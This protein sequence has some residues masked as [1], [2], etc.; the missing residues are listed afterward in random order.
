VVT[1]NPVTL[2]AERAEQ[3]AL[4]GQRRHFRL[5]VLHLVALV[6]ASL[7]QVFLGYRVKLASVVDAGE[8]VEWVLTNPFVGTLTQVVVITVLI[9]TLASRVLVRRRYWERLW[10][11][12]RLV[13]EEIKRGVWRSA[14]KDL[15][16]GPTAVSELDSLLA[17][18]SRLLD[19]AVGDRVHKT[20][21]MLASG[22]ASG[23]SNALAQEMLE[24]PP[25]V[26][27]GV[28]CDQ[29]LREQ[30]TWLRSRVQSLTT[31]RR[32]FGAILVISESVAVVLAISILTGWLPLLIGNLMFPLLTLGAAVL[33]WMSQRGYAELANRYSA[34]ADLLER[35]LA[36]L[37]ELMGTQPL[38]T[39]GLARCIRSMEDAMARENHQWVI[40][41]GYAADV[42]ALCMVVDE[43]GLK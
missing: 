32:T 21:A 5:I 4:I 18:A 42:D 16:A 7:M 25:Q 13:A 3:Y 26:R 11:V 10:C 8:R 29:R 43:E 15:P 22:A 28:Y 30:M 37:Q 12:G 17:R 9:A 31:R 39:K 24:M 6:S 1:G 19:D 34:L 23:T 14:F 33:A 38:D 35:H 41:R 2:V 20:S 40:R 36:R 27:A